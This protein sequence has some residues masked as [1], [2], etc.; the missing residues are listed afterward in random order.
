MKQITKQLLVVVP[1]LTVAAA[2]WWYF[3]PANPHNP[4]ALW[5]LISQRCVVGMEQQSNPAP[6][7]KVDEAQ[8]YVT[9]KDRNGPLQYLVMPVAKITGT[10]SPALLAANAPKF[11]ALAWDERHLLAE[12]Y[13]Q[14]IADS[15]LSL[16]INSEYGRTQNQMHIH[17]SCL[18]TDIRSALNTLAP[19]LTDQWQNV[20]LD[21]SDYQIRSLSESELHAESS[22][23]RIA[24]ELGVEQDDMGK[25]GVA[26]T[27]LPDNR[28]ALLALRASWFGLEKASP[29]LLQDHSCSILTPAP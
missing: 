19:Q 20:E 22:F 4:D 11:F 29:E 6:C 21:G 24:R 18:R 1:I 12:K 26:L 27:T 25:Y 14:P 3:A 23:K 16:A 9:L 7:T 5:Q 28:L 13:G 8:G 2:L 17:I 15:A 10:E